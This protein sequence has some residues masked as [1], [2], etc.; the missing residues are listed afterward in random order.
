MPIILHRGR[1][2]KMNSL[3][4][5]VARRAVPLQRERGCRAIRALD[6]LVG[7][8]VDMLAQVGRWDYNGSS[9]P[10]MRSCLL[11]NLPEATASLA[12]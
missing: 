7:G 1:V 12:R 2:I 6:R 9:C 4:G 10:Q 5:K 8:E 11:V 3:G